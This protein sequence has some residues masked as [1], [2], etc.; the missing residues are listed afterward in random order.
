MCG[1][2]ETGSTSATRLL[3][4]LPIP[5][6]VLLVLLPPLLQQGAKRPGWWIAS[7]VLAVAVG[8]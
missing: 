5:L 7:A 3:R 4:L 6:L 1:E 2:C 8:I